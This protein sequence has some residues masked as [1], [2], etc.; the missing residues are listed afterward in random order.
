MSFDQLQDRI[1]AVKSPVAAELDLRPKNLPPA[2][3]ARHTARLGETLLAAA[4]AAEEFGRSLIDGLWDTVPAVV[5]PVSA[6]EAM[7]WRGLE[8]LEHLIAYAKGRGLFTIA[9]GNRVDFGSAAADYGSAWLG[10]TQV[11]NT[12]CSVF[13]ADCATFCGYTGSDGLRPVLECC[14]VREKCALLLVKTPNPS[15]SELEDLVSGD[16]LVH[17]AVGDLIP[18]LAQDTAGSKYGYRALGAVV[19]TPYPAEMKQLRRR[20]DRVFF[21]VP[22]CDTPESMDIAQHAF[23]EYGRGAAVSVCRPIL[24]ACREGGDCAQAAH[25]AAE[26]LR[27][28]WMDYVTLL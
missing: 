12:S 20:L 7:G 18:R 2:L 27:R 11:G 1:R 16:R 15:A 21:L 8:V 4:Q 6:F 19:G 9:G 23:D 14:A 13:D 10:H 3:L 22:C 26:E 28:A 24:D 17:T 5:F 25:A